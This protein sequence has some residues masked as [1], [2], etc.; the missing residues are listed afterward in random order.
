MHDYLEDSILYISYIY[1]NLYFSHR[2]NVVVSFEHGKR[3]FPDVQ[4]FQTSV[5]AV[6]LAWVE[7]LLFIAVCPY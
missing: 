3:R 4:L 6:T 5:I 7:A 2:L 1:H